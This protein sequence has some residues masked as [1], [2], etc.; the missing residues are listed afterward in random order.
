MSDLGRRL[1][2]GLA[3]VVAGVMAVG[4]AFIFGGIASPIRGDRGVLAVPPDGTTVAT[5]L[6]DGRPVF[7]VNDPGSGIGVVDAQA[8]AA[9]SRIGVA[10]SWCPESRLFVD[11][12]HGSAYTPDGTLRWGPSETGLAAYDAR[13]SGD[14]PSQVVV[15]ADRSGRGRGP[16]TDGPPEVAC[17][18]GWIGHEPGADEAFDPSVA[19]AQ[20]PPGW[21]WLEGSVRMV[22]GEARLCDAQPDDCTSS[23]A[24]GGIDP[25]SRPGNSLSG[26][27]IGRVRDGVIEGLIFV[28]DPEED[29]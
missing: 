3:A 25:A 22:N 15:G 21:I 19:V 11:R 29:P 7:V 9:T 26:D 28:P 17:R 8:D 13:P 14:D 18:G 20:E 6:D 10:V 16:E 5:I 1:L 2:I 24:I 12:V 4:Y 27:F 23:V